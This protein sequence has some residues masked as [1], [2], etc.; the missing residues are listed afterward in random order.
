MSGLS[1]GTIVIEAGPTSGAKMQA[2]LALRH[3]RPVFLL[4]SLVDLHDWGRDYTTK[5]RH[6][7][8]AIA[9]VTV[10]DVL[11]AIDASRPI[12]VEQL[13]LGFDG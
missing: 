1:R 7:T 12:E 8:R 3:G 10:D 4:Q 6:G 13:A 5:G 2:R 11:E 9:V